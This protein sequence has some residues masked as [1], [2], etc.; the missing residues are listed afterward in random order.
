MSVNINNV[1]THFIV[2]GI[3]MMLDKNCLREMGLNVK[4]IAE[5]TAILNCGDYAAQID[6]LRK[7]RVRI[8]D[9]V[10]IKEQSMQKIDYV[11]HEINKKIESSDNSEVK[12]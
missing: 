2:E 1:C 10:H 9:D 11:I 8:L 12:K 7:Y 3:R 5:F 6:A 4:E